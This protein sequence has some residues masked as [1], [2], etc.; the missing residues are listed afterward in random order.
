MIG[1]GG[2]IPT[3]VKRRGT[4]VPLPYYALSASRYRTSKAY[5]LYAVVPF[6]TTVAAALIEYAVEARLTVVIE[7]AAAEA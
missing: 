7:L 2:V 6:R 4:F 5:P 3:H 1:D